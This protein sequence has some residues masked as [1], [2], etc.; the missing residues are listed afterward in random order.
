MGEK[1]GVVKGARRGSVGSG[2]VGGG[3]D[4]GG[5]DVVLSDGTLAVAQ[6]ALGQVGR[7]IIREMARLKW[8]S[9]P[10]PPRYARYGANTAAYRLIFI[11]F[12]LLV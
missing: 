7:Y 12:V 1:V 9:G 3:I 11:G 6:V 4:D 8:K 2:V 10:V 5:G